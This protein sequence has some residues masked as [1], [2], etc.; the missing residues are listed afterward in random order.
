MNDCRRIKALMTDALFDELDRE[1][2]EFFLA[3]LEVC[4][5]CAS[6]FSPLNETLSV[7][8][9]R[10][11]REPGEEF[12]EGF[13][14]KL[15]QRME[16]EMGRGESRPRIPSKTSKQ[17][18]G[19][20]RWVFQASAAVLLLTVGIFIGRSLYLPKGSRTGSG[21][22]Y[23]QNV[24]TDQGHGDLIRRAGNYI[25]KS[26][27]ILLAL[28]NFDPQ[29]EDPYALNLPFQQRISQG[30]VQQASLLKTELEEAKQKR[31]LEL[32]TDLE[33]IL[34]QI[35][36]L[37]EEVDSDAIEIVRDGVDRKGILLKIDLFDMRE[38]ARGTTRSASDPSA[39]RRNNL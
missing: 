1:S 32:V 27:L 10:V 24:E 28:V 12:W 16:E 3:H 23:V 2:Q 21:P 15:N 13:F 26:K 29:E 11:R 9:Q 36:N 6:R 38:T 20:P 37:E 34:L 4:P 18:F 39:S 25:D 8:K 35:A 22:L 19:V 14:P 5:R 33:L 30:L 7:M 31:L 17:W